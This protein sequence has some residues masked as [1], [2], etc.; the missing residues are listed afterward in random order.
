MPF[1]DL[2][3]SCDLL[4]TKPGYGSF[5]EAACNGIPL[6]Y[7]ER[8]DWPEEAFLTQWLEQHGRCH[9][10]SRESFESGKIDQELLSISLP[11]TSTRP[12]PSGINDC[13]VELS[14]FLQGDTLCENT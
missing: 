6:L 9:R 13:V 10:I 8:G 12:R 1:I 7:V 5:T 14:R 3:T 2:L 11:A 4:I